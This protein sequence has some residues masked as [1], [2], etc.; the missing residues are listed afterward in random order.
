MQYII[1]A[2][3]EGIDFDHYLAYL[4]SVREQLPA[5]AVKGTDLFPLLI[6]TPQRRTRNPCPPYEGD[7][8]GRGFGRAIAARPYLIRP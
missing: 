6:A 3:N 7:S 4:Q 5:Q 8:A 2:A 1:S